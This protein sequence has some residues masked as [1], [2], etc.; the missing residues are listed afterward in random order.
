[1]K[2]MVPHFRY[3]HTCSW[4]FTYRKNIVLLVCDNYLLKTAL[5][6]LR[7][8]MLLNPCK[9]DALTWLT[10]FLFSLESNSINKLSLAVFRLSIKSTVSTKSNPILIDDKL[11]SLIQ[12][13]ASRSWIR[14]LSFPVGK[15]TWKS[16]IYE[17]VIIVNFDRSFIQTKK[18]EEKIKQTI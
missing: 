13:N 17:K 10:V 14:T 16:E 18:L 15:R 11:Y 9:I 6:I 4:N 2:H 12:C 1:M 5:L 7:L 8:F 3:R